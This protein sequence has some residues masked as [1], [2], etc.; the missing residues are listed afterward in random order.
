MLDTTSI[1]TSEC[2]PPP[3]AQLDGAAEEEVPGSP[4][5]TRK[6][7]MV[8]ALS[9]LLAQD[10][11]E[12]LLFL[13]LDVM[14]T[15][16]R[17]ALL[18]L[19]DRWGF[20]DH[21]LIAQPIDPGFPWDTVHLP[22]GTDDVA[23]NTGFMFLR[24]RPRTRQ[25]VQQWQRCPLVDKFCE[26]ALDTWWSCEQGVYNVFI[27]PTLAP[28]ELLILPCD[29][30]NGHEGS[31]YPGL[32]SNCSGRFVSHFWGWDGHKKATAAFQKQ[33][34]RYAKDAMLHHASNHGQLQEFT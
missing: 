17:M 10:R 31:G 22:N 27:R 32:P 23:L 4:G 15:D 26:W 19:L 21:H 11:C 1:T 6:W 7:Q 29:E 13:D 28:E 2:A 18:D 34:L 24:D 14:I 3:C 5:C 30:A 16:F 20:K 9:N 25:L 12:L 8:A 33:I